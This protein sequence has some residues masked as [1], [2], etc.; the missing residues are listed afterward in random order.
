MRP[1]ALVFRSSVLA[2]LLASVALAQTAVPTV[3]RWQSGTSN[4]DWKMSNGS[5]T[6]TLRQDG[7]TLMVALTKFG[8]YQVALVTV[9]NE[10][11]QRIEVVPSRI[12]LEQVEPEHAPYTY[13][14]PD[15]L[16][17]SVRHISRWAYVGAAMAGMGTQE[18][19]A[20]I[21]NSDGS[22]STATITTR[23]SAAQDRAIE[24]INRGRDLRAARASIIQTDALRENTVLPGED[25][26]GSVF[27]A[28][29]KHYGKYYRYKG[30]LETVLRVP[31]SDYVFEFPFVFASLVE[32][33]K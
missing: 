8:P 13:Q 9:F 24:N 32:V 2:I 33:K 22:T 23:D 5:L 12:T 7:L 18:S 26:S 31:V 16:A 30:K 28:V 10:T 20:T 27:F 17:K 3:V 29:P 6:L 14:D 11:H 15:K 1:Q 25:V 19:Q 4:S 21:T